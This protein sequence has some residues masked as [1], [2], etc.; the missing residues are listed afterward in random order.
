MKKSS[1]HVSLSTSNATPYG[2][3]VGAGQFAAARLERVDERHG[4]AIERR[5]PRRRRRSQVRL[6]RDVAQIL[7]RQHAEI[8][9]VAQNARHR[10]RHRGKQL[11]GV[12]ERQRRRTRTAPHR[13][14]A[15][16]SRPAPAARGSSGGRTRRRS[17]RR[18][19]RPRDAVAIEIGLDGTGT[20]ESDMDVSIYRS[21]DRSIDLFGS[22][23]ISPID[24]AASLVAGRH[25]G[26][27]HEHG[28]RGLEA[29]RHAHVRH[30][31]LGRARRAAPIAAPG[32][33]MLFVTRAPGATT[34]AW[35]DRRRRRPSA[36]AAVQVVVRR[37]DVKNGAVDAMRA[38][39]AGGR[40]RS[41]LAIDAVDGFGRHAVRQRVEHGRRRDL[42]AD[43]VPARR[44]RGRAARSR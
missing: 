41:A 19:G 7:E 11:R 34:R 21:M 3:Y 20:R 22:T 32:Q 6:Q 10:H 1:S 37:A 44:R 14:R 2:R 8:V 23:R 17:A 26:R 15:R 18:R 40:G 43:E 16:T 42:H 25:D 35:L 29:R 5:V 30:D 36:S 12:H 4:L 9:G 13:P 27:R 24:A 33:T 38:D 31:A 28:S 39:A